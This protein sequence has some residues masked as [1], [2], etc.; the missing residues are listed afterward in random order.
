MVFVWSVQAL[1]KPT[2]MSHLLLIKCIIN[3]VVSKQYLVLF[4][5]LNLMNLMFHTFLGSRIN[6]EELPNTYVVGWNTS[7]PSELV[8]SETKS[9][10]MHLVFIIQC[11]IYNCA[12]I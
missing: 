10:I 2:L 3:L 1:M 4:E 8:V 6:P 11:N 9:I 12:Y 5:I 7:S